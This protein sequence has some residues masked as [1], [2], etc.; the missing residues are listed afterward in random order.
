MEEL[1]VTDKPGTATTFGARFAR[2]FRGAL[3]MSA[4]GAVM[5]AASAQS[6][7]ADAIPPKNGSQYVIGWSFH[8]DPLNEFW[9]LFID[10]MTSTLEAG[11]A[12]VIFCSGQGDATK[13]ADCVD[14]FLTQNVDAMVIAS[15]D[16]AAIIGPT[17][18]A[19]EAGVPVFMWLN[20]VAAS[21]G[22]KVLMGNETGDQPAGSGAGQAIVDAL[23]AK[24]GSAKGKVLE[25]QGLMS[26]TLA[27]VRSAGLHE[28]TDKYPE[29]IV[30]AKAGDFDTGKAATIIQDWITANPDTDAIW[31][32]SD[33]NYTPAARAALMAV[34]RWV[35]AG[36]AGHVI[37]VGMDGSNLAVNAAKCGYMDYV[38]DFTFPQI[39]PMLAQQVL[40][41]LETGSV[42]AVGDVVPVTDS[43]ITGVPVIERAEFAGPILSIP[44]FGITPE[45]AE[46]PILFANKYQGAPNGLSVCE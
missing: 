28:I 40:R 43:T 32:A 5:V 15:T 20:G 42:A 25:V 36:E 4:L 41:Y 16:S 13:Q 29:I 39:S 2:A 33:A 31:L 9:K 11:G 17:L 12:K 8:N 30:T 37:L 7:S 26:Q 46:N 38:A 22:V 3:T 23:I 6:A 1:G 19:N 44:I 35:K 18:K 34:G 27:Q 14:Q 21:S 45:T 24:Y 10:S